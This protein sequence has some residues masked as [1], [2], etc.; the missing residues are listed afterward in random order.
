M[1]INEIKKLSKDEF[2]EM[3]KDSLPVD[4]ETAYERIQNSKSGWVQIQKSDRSVKEHG[5]TQAFGE[6]LSLQLDNSQRWYHT[7]TI[8]T[9][10]WEEEYFD[11]L[12]SRY[13]FKFKESDLEREI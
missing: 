6:G 9:I 8:Q 1:K 4:V 7:S 10:N 3:F 5:Y 2:I 13:Y 12:N 11:T